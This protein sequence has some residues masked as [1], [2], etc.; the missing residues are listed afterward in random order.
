[1][2]TGLTGRALFDPPPLID[3]A[4]AAAD[5]AAF[6]QRAAGDRHARQTRWRGRKRQAL[7]EQ[8]LA[9]AETEGLDA[10]EI[11]KRLPVTP[12]L[13]DIFLTEDQ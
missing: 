3:S 12:I 10:L 8:V 5:K 7:K 13:A 4:L 1:M 6:M 11:S 9:L 2:A